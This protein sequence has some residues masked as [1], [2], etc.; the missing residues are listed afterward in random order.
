MMRHGSLFSGIGGFDL[1]SDKMGWENVFH[2]EINP[3]CRKVLKYYWPKALSYED[4]QTTDFTVWRGK[5]D[6]LTG[7]FPCQPYSIAG[8]RKGKEDARHLWPEM[9]R[10]I[11]EVQPGYI[12]AENVPGIISW[13]GGLVFEE[14]QTDLE[15]E[16]YEVFAVIL[17]A[18]GVNA[19]HRRDRVWFIAHSTSKLQ[20]RNEPGKCGDEKQQDV[21]QEYRKTNTEQPGTMGKNGITTHTTGERRKNREQPGGFSDYEKNRTGMDFWA[22]RFG[23]DELITNATGDRWKWER[24]KIENEEGLQKEPGN[25]RELEGRFEGLCSDEISTYAGCSERENGL[26]GKEQGRETTEFGDSYT[27][28][29]RFSNFPTTKPT[30]CGRDDGFPAGLDGI[31]FPKWRNESIKGY[32]NAIV[33]QIAYEIF[34]V[35]E[36]MITV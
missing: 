18:C 36:K 16:G 3:F 26:H 27:K 7:G 28:F 12:V 31:T 19:P 24:Q 5:I 11:R 34:E 21:Q 30:I 25:N 4:I 17:P 32:G 6:I 22:E 14:V 15:N 8:E 33:P 9:L 29:G 13:N 23:E 20:Q 1:A 2:C 35:I 10:A